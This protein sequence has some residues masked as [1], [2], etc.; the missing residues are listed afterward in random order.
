MSLVSVNDHADDRFAAPAPLPTATTRETW[1]EL[2]ALARDRRGLTAAAL[3]ALVAG[4]AV[5]LL[6]PPLLGQIVNLVV[7][8][9]GA[10]S[11]TTPALLLFAVAAAQAALTALGG[12]LV[13][14]LGET[15]LAQLRERVL[16]HAL[17]VPL[18]RIERA[19]SGDL[20]ARVSDDSALVAAA[21]RSSLPAFAGAGLTIALTV[22]ALALLDW[23][24]ALAGLAAAPIQLHTLRWYLRASGPLYAAERVAAARRSQALLDALGGAPTVRAFGFGEEQLGAVRGGSYQALER[25]LASNRLAS[26]FYGRLNLAELVG[27]AAILAV[28]YWLVGD[29]RA[30]VGTATAAALY[31]HR[32]F[33]PVNTLLGL[34]DTA[35][36]AAAGLARLVGVAHM[37]LERGSTQAQE[38]G[39]AARPR[40]VAWRGDGAPASPPAPRD[41][42]ATLDGVV[43]GYT[44]GRPVLDGIDLRISPGE[45][46]ALVGASGAGKS[47]LGKLLAGVHAVDRGRVALGSVPLERL[48]P[49]RLRRHVA[50][51]TQEV[52][53]FAGTLADDLRL[54][55]PA[56]SDERLRDALR[57]VGAEPWLETLD[58]GLETTVGDGGHRLTATQAQQVALARVIL[59]DPA[60][61]VLDEATADAGSAGARM[62]DAAAAEALRGRT[63]L[64]VAH[65]LSQASQA[66]RVVV[67]ADGRVVESGPHDELAAAGGEYARLWAAWAGARA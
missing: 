47:T 49:A 54:A 17:G 7:D 67:L 9:R 57:A 65:R 43:F 55:D 19:G 20:L 46:V 52:H 60:I 22:V 12:V 2:Q 21:V 41:A 11:I 37:P 44:L 6:V 48:D 5:G 39:P 14:R 61:I 38:P 36:Q 53:V 27:L 8:G 66:D 58:D 40:R 3:G 50:L 33:D 35:Q 51:V 10:G 29:G 30:T 32:L 18:D 28:G 4:T 62:L 16:E 13:A 64:I 23:R 31:F 56:A 25:A 24:F 34:F 45:H 59:L 63:A 26:R 15:L 42:G 1:R